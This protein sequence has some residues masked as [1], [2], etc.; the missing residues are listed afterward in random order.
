MSLSSP[1]LARVESAVVV[2]PRVDKTNP[3]S[4]LFV[5]LSFHS[6]R[7]ERKRMDLVAEDANPGFVQP[8]PVRLSLSFSSPN[9]PSSP[10]PFFSLPN[11][12][13]YSDSSYNQTQQHTY[14]SNG[15]TSFSSSSYTPVPTSSSPPPPPHMNDFGPSQSFAGA[16]GTYPHSNNTPSSQ[17][18]RSPPTSMTSAQA[19][20]LEAQRSRSGAG[21]SSSSQSAHRGGGASSTFVSPGM[22]RNEEEEEEQ[23]VVHEDAG[24][25]RVE[26]PPVYVDRS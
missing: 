11:H 25:A 4:S 7:V 22:G 26:L 9:F 13:Q 17:Q 8:F 1:S 19:K 5:S 18:N 23:V 15:P 2:P 10:L 14:P 24:P 16:A 6:S 3:P 21:S 20:A 12:A